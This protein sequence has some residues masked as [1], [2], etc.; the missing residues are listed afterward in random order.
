MR[1]KK[2]L[3]DNLLNVCEKVLV[4]NS[5]AHFGGKKTFRNCEGKLSGASNP[6]LARMRFFDR[7]R[8]FN[9]C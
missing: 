4:K 8:E 2:M 6:I 7:F 9:F 5:G 1:F 3:R